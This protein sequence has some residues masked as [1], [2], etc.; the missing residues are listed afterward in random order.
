MVVKIRK[1]QKG[2]GQGRA[3]E[4]FVDSECYEAYK[5]LTGRVALDE[6]MKRALE[7]FG[8]EFEVIK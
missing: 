2:Q 4:Y 6:K 5:Y 3:W 7:V 8:V 1:D